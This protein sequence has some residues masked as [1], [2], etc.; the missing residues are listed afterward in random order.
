MRLLPFIARL[1]TIGLIYAV[2]GYIYGV[3]AAMPSSTLESPP[4][5]QRPPTWTRAELNACHAERTV[6]SIHWGN[7]LHYRIADQVT[8]R[9][10]VG[11]V[12]AALDVA[13]L[14]VNNIGL[15]ISMASEWPFSGTN[16]HGGDIQYMHAP[17]H[18]TLH[19]DLYHMIESFKLASDAVLAHI[20][21]K[22]NG[23][24]GGNVLIYCNMGISRSVSA[25]IYTLMV[26]DKEG[27]HSFAD[28]LKTVKDVRPIANP[29][30]HYRYTLEYMDPSRRQNKVEL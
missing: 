20:E 22:K 27:R 12:C 11:S 18:D 5:A 2:A 17:L 1:S 30:S 19:E 4:T 10:W 21:T 14:R 13:F 25:T 23:A 7:P 15:V 26:M 16:A 28:H 6:A 29:N 3:A 8:P 9:I 24:Q